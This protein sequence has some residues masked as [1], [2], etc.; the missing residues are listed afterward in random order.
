MRK[1]VDTGS[2]TEEE[3]AALRSV[4]EGLGA[5]LDQADRGETE[6]GEAAIARAFEAAMEEAERRCGAVPRSVRRATFR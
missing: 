3:R 1:R 6:E 5:G 2:F 4:S